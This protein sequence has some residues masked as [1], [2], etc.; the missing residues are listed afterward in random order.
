MQKLPDKFIERM[1]K[2]LPET[3]WAAFF[4]CYDKKPFKGV[5]LNQLRGSRCALKPLLPF[6][7]APVAWEEN[8]Y[9]TSAEKLGA[10]PFHFAGVF[11]SQEPSAMCAAPLLEVKAG[12]KVLDLCSAPGGKGTQLACEMDGKGIIVLNEPVSSRAK[13]LS[14]NVERMGVKNA[15]VLNEY[16]DALARKFTGYFDK[17]LVDAPCSGEGM[18]RKNA[19]EAL[20]EWSEE[21]VTMCAERQAQILDEATK[22]LRAGGRLVYSTCTFSTEEDEGQVCDYLKKHP[23]MRLIRKEKLYPHKVDGEGHFAALFEKVSGEAASGLKELKPSVSKTAEK[24]YRE[25][26]NAFFTMPFAE[27]LHEA[28]GVLYEL[29]EGVFD[30]KGLQTLRVGVRLG[31]MKNGRFEPSHSL[32]MSVKCSECKNAV[33][34]SA[35]DTRVTKYLRG[36]TLDSATQNGWCAVFVEGQPLGLGKAVNGVIKNHLPKGLRLVHSSEPVK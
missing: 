9:Y 6:L 8:G 23:E 35:E 34:L 3:E 33:D 26:E 22:M 19:E 10:D 15:V 30:W 11:Y 32:V 27:R 36:E 21:N 2:Q 12:E 18:F 5:R 31:E 25:F 17:I 20:S 28:N 7:G 4:A 14:H 13:I 16:P 1:K 29:P 24:A